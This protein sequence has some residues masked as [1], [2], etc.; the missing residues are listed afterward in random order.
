MSTSA[1]SHEP[2]ALALAEGAVH[3]LRRKGLTALTE[4]YCGSLPFVLGLLFFWSD[5]T[6]STFARSY[7]APAAAGI[8]LLFIWM[9]VWHVRFCRRLLSVLQ[10]TPSAE[11]WPMHRMWSTAARQAAIH[12]TGLVA[13]PLASIILL[14]LAWVYAFY[15][16]AT[17]LDGPEEST[18][19][20][21]WRTALEQ[22]MLWPGQNHLLLSIFIGFGLAVFLNL[23]VTILSLPH[24][25]KALTGAE[26]TFVLTGWRML[27]TTFLAV[28]FGLSYLCIDPIIKA[29]YVL[30]C[31]Y[32]RSQ[33]SGDDLRA[34]LKRFMV[35]AALIIVTMSIV[36]H[37]FG[38]EDF[39]M[40]DRFS[41]EIRHNE[42]TVNRLDRAITQVL[43]QRRFT[44][45][46]PRQKLEEPREGTWLFRMLTWMGNK[47]KSL[48]QSLGRW[49]N[50]FIDWLLGLFP[51]PEFQDPEK[52]QS[53]VEIIRVLFYVIGGCL[54]LIGGILLYRWRRRSRKLDHSQGE[55]L[56]PA[57]IDLTDEN[58]TADDL[59]FD[60]WLALARELM[61][62]KELRSAQR[63]LY[64]AVLAHLADYGR[65]AIARYKSNRDYYQ[66]LTRHAHAEPELVQLF[67]RCVL[68]FERAWYGMYAVNQK[69]IEQFIGFQERIVVL[70]QE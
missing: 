32:G 43:E 14:P 23:A 20:K 61:T 25:L 18:F 64:L 12:A 39:P 46:L 9:K 15:Q 67:N 44:W 30:R 21:V 26:T 13:L 35:A 45:R 19:R 50:Q 42:D 4:Y 48:F 6:R 3:L 63:A 38:Q 65:L 36:P 60:R 27:N 29:A 28:L 41:S 57:E 22:A 2:S 8:A 69:Q 16:N 52:R 40:P 55:A 5:M 34:A 70:V 1:P 10:E 31:Y 47:I 17:I 66:E 37:G 62:K 53:R 24:L 51:T 59:P 54:L 11:P 7:C 58:V 56:A 68:A 49:I 33:R